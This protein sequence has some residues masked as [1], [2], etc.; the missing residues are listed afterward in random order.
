MCGKSLTRTVVITGGP[1]FDE[2]ASLI[3]PGDRVVCAD[4]GVD[5]AIANSIRPDE[6]YGD[7]DSIS[8][9]GKNFIEVSGIS[10]KTFPVEKDMT[11][12]ELAIRSCDPS[13]EILLICSLQGRPDHV[14]TNILLVSRLRR[15]G[16]SIICSDGH[17]DIIPL[18]GKDEIHIDEV[19]DPSCKAISLI[20]VSDEVTGVTAN[21]LYYPLNDATIV[22]GSSFTNSN[23]LSRGSSS[24]S[25]SV[26]SGELLV[27]ITDKV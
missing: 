13:S 1:I 23:E 2:A 26:N 16:R 22:R 27:V 14:L 7:L 12:T 18:Y 9:E 19:L 25:V 3:L 11:D 5:Y 17:T 4:S 20:P 21:G 6:V 24:F 8:A 15:E 10:L